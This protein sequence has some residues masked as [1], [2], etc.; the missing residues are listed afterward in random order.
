M[1]TQ[2]PALDY[3]DEAADRNGVPR[4]VLRSMARV[5]SARNPG[6]VSSRGARGEFQV[7]PATARSLGFTPEDMH[8]PAKGAQAGAAYVKQLYDRFGDWDTAVEAY[9]AGP[10]RVAYRRKMGI[11]LPSET[12]NHIEKIR[13]AQAA[14]ALESATGVNR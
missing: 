8:D 14:M 10:A 9:N 11:A 1:A 7:M 5:E 2:L 12:R 4:P 3:I 6:A 13:G